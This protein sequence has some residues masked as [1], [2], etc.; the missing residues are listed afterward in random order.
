MDGPGSRD[1]YTKWSKSER[2]RKVSYDIVYMYN[3][4]KCCKWTYLQNRNR[5]T[6]IDNKP[7]TTKEERLGEIN[8]ELEISI[9]KQLYIK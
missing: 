5:L 3:I 8:Q 7:M 1:Y 4:K 2:E 9:Y 6:D